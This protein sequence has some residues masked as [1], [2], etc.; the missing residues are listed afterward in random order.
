[1]AYGSE[2][3]ALPTPGAVG[4]TY[5]TVD[6][7]FAGAVAVRGGSV[8]LPAAGA[9]SWWQ[10]FDSFPARA[11][12][13]EMFQVSASATLRV[14]WVLTEA[15][16]LIA[17]HTVDF[18]VTASIGSQILACTKQLYRGRWNHLRVVVVPGNAPAGSVAFFVNGSAAGSAVG[19]DTSWDGSADTVNRVVLYPG[20]GGIAAVT[21]DGPDAAV[22]SPRAVL[23][24]SDVEVAFSPSVAG[25]NYAM[26]DDAGAHDGDATYTHHDQPDVRDVFGFGPSGLSGA[27]ACH[28]VSQR[29]VARSLDAAAGRR[30]RAVLIKGGVSAVGTDQDVSDVFSEFREGWDIDPSTAAPWADLAAAELAVGGYRNV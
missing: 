16:G 5:D 7:P 25:P 24:T 2:S 9:I 29:W 30:T 17:W 11:G 1:M 18:S 6:V 8:T 22:I 13:L 19:V 27:L 20:T 3:F 28:G 21:W 26:V 10:K 23:P 15:P 4:V 12:V 14:G